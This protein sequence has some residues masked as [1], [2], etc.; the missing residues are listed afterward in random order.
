MRYE[1]FSFVIPVES[2]DYDLLSKDVIDSINKIMNDAIESQT[3]QIMIQTNL[4]QGLPME[5]INKIAGPL[6][7]AWAYETFYKVMENTDN[8]VRL[9]NVE[10][11]ERQ[12]IAD[13]LLQ[14]KTN[15]PGRYGVSADVD[16]KATSEDIESSGKGPNIS[17]YAKIRTAY[18]E[19]P[20]YIF[21]VLSI[22]HKVY[23]NRN[24]KDLLTESVMEIISHTAFD[25]KYV[26]EDD[27][28]YNPALGH[29][30]LQIR[31]INHVSTTKRTTWEFCQLLDQKFLASSRRSISDF[32]ELAARYG[33]IKNG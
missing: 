30:Q 12:N 7:E 28:Y 13:I 32:R 18:V 8:E 26:A 16:V 6:V 9:I 23:T 21:I 31:D 1:D 4:R 24:K 20:D 27:L 3:N 14:F 10:A 25:I 19:D 11:K 2:T 33:W 22:K 5:N 29:G 17:S 15:R